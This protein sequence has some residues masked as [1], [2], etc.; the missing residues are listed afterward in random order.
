MSAVATAVAVVAGATA[1]VAWIFGA[2]SP[3]FGS[4]G[5]IE[6]TAG[7]AIWATLHATLTVG[8]A[9]AVLGAKGDAWFRVLLRCDPRNVDEARALYGF[10]GASA[11]AWTGAA[12]LPLDWEAWWQRWPLPLFCGTAVG[13]LLAC[14]AVRLSWGQREERAR[15]EREWGKGFRLSA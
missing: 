9:W 1:V 14:A 13:F 10:A 5:E 3:S 7:L 2:P 4:T 15:G 11:G 6:A 8:P 12:V